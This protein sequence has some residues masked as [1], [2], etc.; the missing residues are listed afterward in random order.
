MV[1]KLSRIIEVVD[2]LL[3]FD[4][5]NA[6]PGEL[7]NAQLMAQKLITKY[8]IQE[9]Q[10]KG[11]KTIVELYIEIPG[12]YVI[13]KTLLLH[14]IAKNNFC[15]VARGKGHAVVYGQESD[16]QL[17]K[18]LYAHLLMDMVN[19]MDKNLDSVKDTRSWKKSFFSGYSLKVG[20]RL[21][22]AKQQLYDTVLK[23]KQ[24]LIEEFWNDLP[25]KSSSAGKVTSFLGYSKGRDSGS[26]ADLGQVHITE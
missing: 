8:Q 13:D 19:E 14:T 21:E 7:H 17:V 1:D 15:K 26:R 10:L 2:K 24:Q 18:T 25:K 4:E 5:N 16:V 9:A 11:S 23:D 6:S 20:E 22:Q 12:P 3:G